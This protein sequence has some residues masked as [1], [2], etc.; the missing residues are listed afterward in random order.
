MN[1]DRNRIDTL[2][3][4]VG[5]SDK[6]RLTTLYNATVS[7][8]KA[9]N[10][11][12]TASKLRDWQASEKALA[13]AVADVEG[14]GTALQ[15][16]DTTVGTIADVARWLRVEGY[17]APGRDEPIKKSKVYQD[18][19]SGLLS[20]ADK[21]AITMTEVMA[22]VAR[23]QL[24]QAGFNRADEAEDLNIQKL[25]HETRKAKED[26][27]RK[28]FENARDRGLYRKIDEVELH[29]AMKI[30]TLEAGLK[31]AVRTNASDW[32]AAIEKA[33]NKPQALCDQVYPVIDE[34][35]DEF[36]RMDEIG[37]VVK[38]RD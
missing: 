36:G 28:E 38:R 35:L 29:T 1:I 6:A 37:V 27:D 31:H 14:S 7:T 3:K 32:I 2:L 34:L 9:Y 22:Y 13:E 20:F 15:D 5:D 26:A 33:R 8:L 10:Q 24:M 18:R 19:R 11:E 16:R 23:A 30:A 4:T 25:R 17:C 21:K 12:S